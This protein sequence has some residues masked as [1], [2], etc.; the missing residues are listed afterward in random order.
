MA[1]VLYPCFCA[2]LALLTHCQ[3]DA[4]SSRE[5]KYVTV[6]LNDSL[7]RY[8]SVEIAILVSGD[9]TKVVGKMWSG[10][11]TD[12]SAVPSFR[13]ENGENRNLAI[14]V[15]GFDSTGALTL[16]MLI[17][18]DGGTQTVADLPVPKPVDPIDP[19]DTVRAR[20]STKLAS[21]SVAP[22][23]LTP[24]FD[25]G[26]AEY[27]VSLTYAESS[28][29]LTAKTV[30]RDAEAKVGAEAGHMRGRISD[31]IEM[32]VGENT[33]RIRV[34]AGFEAFT[35]TLLVTRAAKPV[36]TVTVPA[37]S[38]MKAWAHHRDVDIKINQL[39]LTAGG[40]LRYCPMLIRLN[41]GNFDFSQAAA[42]GKDIRLTSAGGKPLPFEIARWEA[43]SISPEADIWVRLEAIR[44]ED[45]AARVIL[46]YGNPAATDASEPSQV[47]SES[48]GFSGAWH[49]S[50]TAKG[51]AGEFRDATGRHHGMGG[52]GDGK[53]LTA[54]VQGLVGYGQDFTAGGLLDNFLGVSTGNG[55][56]VIN[57][58]RSFDPG[59][60]SWTFQAWI[61]RTGSTDAVIFQ[62][63]DEWVAGRQRF[64]IVCTGGGANQ[65]MIQREG[66]QLFT[67][68][69]L[70]VNVFTQL[71]FVYTGARVEIYV[72]GFLR[73]TKVF[74]Q[75]GEP[76]GKA[77]LGANEP[78]GSEEGFTG[79]MD[80]TW[81]SSIVRSADW[82]RFSYES[83]RP[84]SF[85][86][87]VQPP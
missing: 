68:V 64:Q 4:P 8:D 58:P 82:V 45:D 53:N 6:H 63:G 27:R 85:I 15:R 41:R 47:F 28:L 79:V 67:N 74:T 20:R 71:T 12:P 77:I 34:E 70:P 43:N 49:L 36:D 40:T 23:T 84:K 17:S 22:G 2:L 61:K 72:D 81:F 55:Q 46:Y 25:S 86:V 87:I 31:P 66:A 16:N 1:W 73:E 54:R 24:D 26:R 37:D 50:E 75:G 3:F 7:K 29:S 60:S 33:V 76:I 30:D 18:K 35:Y 42:G 62:K 57:L 69:Y 65:I 32:D 59:N 83:Q 52:T 38:A 48:E 13:L 10:P 9:T 78:D 14:R 39:G 5:E 11:L 21:L 56:S 51:Q 19:V 44:H 80:E